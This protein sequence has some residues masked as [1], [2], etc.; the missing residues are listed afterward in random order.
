VNKLE[1]AHAFAL[2]GIDVG[3]LNSN[4]SLDLLVAH[5]WQYA[6]LML[7]EDEKRK[8]KSLPEVLNDDFVIDW[9]YVSK[10]Y[11]YW[12]MDKDGKFFWYEREPRRNDMEFYQNCDMCLAPDFG[13]KGDWKK[14]LRKRPE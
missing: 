13:Y 1:L 3:V 12:V 6:D 5:S 9:D 4:Y 11:N 10:R 14:S 2:H 8:D 7:A